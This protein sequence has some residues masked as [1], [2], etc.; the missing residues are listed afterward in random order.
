MTGRIDARRTR[1]LL[2]ALQVARPWHTPVVRDY[3]GNT[4]FSNT[5]VTYAGVYV[6]EIVANYITPP[7]LP[8]IS[9]AMDA[10]RNDAW[11]IVA[12]TADADLFVY[13][14]SG[15]RLGY[16]RTI[17]ISRSGKIVDEVTFA[18]PSAPSTPY[19]KESTLSAAQVMHLHALCAGWSRYPQAFPGNPRAYDGIGVD[20]TY[21]S[22]GRG[23]TVFAGEP[24]S[25]PAAFK[26]VLDY[27]EAL[28]DALP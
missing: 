18:N 1:S 14:G 4:D 15:G 23:K 9:R 21:Y 22:W 8:L 20:A 28:A 7:A 25:Q 26:A 27:V 6:Q 16:R 11:D 2:T 3:S 5:R 17:T 24:Q 10:F 12:L 19:R 13:D